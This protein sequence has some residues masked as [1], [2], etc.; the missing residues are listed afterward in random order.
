MKHFLNVSTAGPLK[1]NAR[2]RRVHAHLRPRPRPFQLLLNK[3][4]QIAMTD[5]ALVM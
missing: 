2:S 3:P 5:E 1:T 4:P